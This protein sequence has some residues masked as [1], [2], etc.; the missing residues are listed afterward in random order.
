MPSVALHLVVA[1]A[2]L[3]QALLACRLLLT[4]K[5]FGKRYAKFKWL[6]PLG[7]ISACVIAMVA[8]VAG[9]LQDKGIRIVGTIPKGGSAG[10]PPRGCMCGRVGSFEHVHTQLCGK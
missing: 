1:S 6:R 9:R 10:A 7:P 2:A 8:V 4:M 3:T 5:F